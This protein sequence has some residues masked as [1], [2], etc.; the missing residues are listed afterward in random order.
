MNTP[1]RVAAWYKEDT[2]PETHY[3]LNEK[4]CELTF[5]RETSQY[6][7]EKT[8]FQAHGVDIDSIH[9]IDTYDHYWHKFIKTIH[10]V[11]MAR[12]LNRKSNS[13]D[14]QY[15]KAYYLRDRDELDRLGKLLEKRSRLKLH[16]V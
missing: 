10:E 15:L 3:S 7:A 16:Q 6:K 2:Y 11:I 8:A 14:S 12:A 9:D 13:L 1:D 5:H 4:T